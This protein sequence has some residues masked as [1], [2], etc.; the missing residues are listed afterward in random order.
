M[1][2][3]LNQILILYVHK[4]TASPSRLLILDKLSFLYLNEVL[5]LPGNSLCRSNISHTNVEQLFVSLELLNRNLTSTSS[6][7]VYLPLSHLTYF[8]T[9]NRNGKN[10]S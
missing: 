5:R 1:F 6:F 9:V 4:S 3:N 7:T 10:R 2:E 8:S